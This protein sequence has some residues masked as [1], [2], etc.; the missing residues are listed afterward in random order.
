V[1]N[2]FWGGALFPLIVLG[3]LM[4]FPWV[5]RRIK[6][7]Y[8][9]HNVLD[10]PRDA[11]GRTAF[12]AAFFVWVAVVFFAGAADRLFLA[13]DVPYI[14]QVWLF[15][16]AFFVAPAVTYVVVLRTVRARRRSALG[17]RPRTAADRA[18]AP[19]R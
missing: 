1:P 13:V 10:R 15:R 2:P 3:V 5:E 6:R 19:G 16:A 17:S 4:A 7:D 14:R 9:Y 12:G 8:A 11:P 18:G